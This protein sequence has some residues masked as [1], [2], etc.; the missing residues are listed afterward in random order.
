MDAAA[1][2]VGVDVSKHTL[3][4]VV[5]SSGRVRQFTNDGAGIDRCITL[6]SS[7]KD[8][9]LIVEATG[10]FEH[11]LVAAATTKGISVVVVNPRQVRDFA[12]ST[13]QLAKTDQ[14]DARMLALFGE[15]VR[16]EPRPL[17]DETLAALQ[18]LVARRVQ[19]IEMLVAERNRL[20][21]SRDTYVRRSITQHVRWLERQLVDVDRDLGSAIKSSPIWRAKDDLLRSVP[22]VGPVTSRTLLAQLPE[23][24]AISRKQI[25]ALVGV[26]PLAKDSGLMRGKRLVWGGRAPVRAALYMAAL[27]ASRCNPTIKAFYVRLLAAGKPKKV[28][29]V[30]CAHKLLLILN[31]MARTSTP[32]TP[33]LG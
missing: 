13:G 16:P 11:A 26:A 25:A 3:D 14:I 33:A 30:A 22:G 9:L 27:V 7:E 29:L 32:W 1:L 15:R 24:G 17:P 23:L 10:G 31:A 8:V 2:V 28:A 21:F 4:V 5:G 6:F 18:A 20:G 12:R 19:I